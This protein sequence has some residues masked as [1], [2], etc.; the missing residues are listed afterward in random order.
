M[1]DS[2]EKPPQYARKCSI[3]NVVEAPAEILQSKR[4]SIPTLQTKPILLKQSSIIVITL[5]C[6]LSIIAIWVF[7]FIPGIL[8]GIPNINP[9]LNKTIN[10]DLLDSINLSS[11]TVNCPDQYVYSKVSNKC[12]PA[13]GRWSNCGY[14]CLYLKQA[15]LAVSAI[16]GVV[17]STYA[18]FS[19]I[20][21]RRTW[22][23]QH[24]PILF[25]ICVNLLLSISFGI[26]DIPGNFVFYCHTKYISLDELNQN[27]GIHIQIQ[28]SFLHYLGLSNRLWFL[29]ALLHILLVICFPMKN[30]FAEKRARLITLIVEN[31]LCFGL[32]VILEMIPYALGIRYYFFD[33]IDMPTLDNTI[34]NAVIGYTPHVIITL[35][36]MTLVICILYKTRMQAIKMK[37]FG[38]GYELQTIEKRLLIFAT[39]YFIISAIIVVSIIV[40]YFIDTQI[41]KAF[42]DYL[43]FITLNS[44]YIDTNNPL[45][46]N[47][48]GKILKNL[49]ATDYQG[50]IEEVTPPFLFFI[51]GMGNRLMFVSVFVVIHVPC[52]C[53][54]K[55]NSKEKITRHSG[56]TIRNPKAQL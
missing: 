8:Q 29:M 11:I 21:L 36:T 17:V 16:I 6:I 34:A 51:R 28:G 46:T 32:P 54:K 4:A 43:S 48:T 20:R 41:N 12:Q 25:C 44:T 18:I 7:F 33:E 3:S 40:H 27:A 2:N 47:E 14:V 38:D 24:Y 52:N 22:K 9:E 13:C 30:I 15:V 55:T 37:E 42:E 10:E 31:S 23:F 56:L 5:L 26:S 49:L 45:T 19:W 50:L 39:I 35:L 53:K 1:M